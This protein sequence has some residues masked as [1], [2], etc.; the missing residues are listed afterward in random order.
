MPVVAAFNPPPG[1]ALVFTPVLQKVVGIQLGISTVHG[2][3]WAIFGKVV[4]SNSNPNPES[5]GAQLVAAAA[6]LDTTNVTIPPKSSQ[7]ISLEGVLSTSLGGAAPCVQIKC[8]SSLAAN[9]QFAR[10]VAISVDA[11]NP[12]PNC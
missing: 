12:A 3:N 6:V 2:S 8:S 4:V 5:V 10:L 7:S 9:A 11:A 1:G